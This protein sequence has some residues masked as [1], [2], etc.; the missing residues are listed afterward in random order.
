MPIARITVTTVSDEG[1]TVV[2]YGQPERAPTGVEPV[3]F[4]FQTKGEDAD[5]GLAERAS[6][7]TPGSGVVVDYVVVAEGWNLARGLSAG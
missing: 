5:V 2:V 7:L 1:D 3:G 4:V 6:R